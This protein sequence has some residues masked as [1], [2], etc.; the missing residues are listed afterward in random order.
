MPC[1][2]GTVA[3]EQEWLHCFL[4]AQIVNSRTVPSGTGPPPRRLTATLATP[5]RLT[6][7]FLTVNAAVLYGGS[8]PQ[9]RSPLRSGVRAGPPPRSI[10]E[11][12]G[13]EPHGSFPGPRKPPEGACGRLLLPK[14]YDVQ[15]VMCVTGRVLW[16]SALPV[17]MGTC[18]GSSVTWVTLKESFRC[19]RDTTEIKC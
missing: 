2:N 9:C 11:G 14:R 7:C 6:W 18:L 10:L 5:P 3:H 4:K 15:S 19:Q 1:V 17:P 8:K 16:T 13:G 12:S